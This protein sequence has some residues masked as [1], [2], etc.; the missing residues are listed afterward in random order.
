[1]KMRDSDPEDK[2]KEDS[3]LMQMLWL[4]GVMLFILMIPIFLVL[5]K[6]RYYQ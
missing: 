1:M 2:D 5:L 3:P 6:I 4:I